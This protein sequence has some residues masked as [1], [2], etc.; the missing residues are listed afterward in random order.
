MSNDLFAGAT[1]RDIRLT[2]MLEEL[3]R[4]LKVRRRVYPRWIDQGKLD[5]VI[6]DRRILCLIA[7]RKRLEAL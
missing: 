3:D 1:Y 5:P 4:E 7:I 2:D 6:A